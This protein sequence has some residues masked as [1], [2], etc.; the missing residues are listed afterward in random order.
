MIG[1]VSNGHNGFENARRMMFP[2]WSEAAGIQVLIAYA[3]PPLP[4]SLSVRDIQRKNGE[5]EVES[6]LCA[7]VC[8]A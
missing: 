7:A 4:L 5:S 2:T 3:I 8:E 1:A 6:V